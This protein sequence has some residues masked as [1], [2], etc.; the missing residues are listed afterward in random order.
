MSPP[1][2]IGK[3]ESFIDNLPTLLAILLDE[4]IFIVIATSRNNTLSASSKG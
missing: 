1:E 3:Y 4:H 2:H